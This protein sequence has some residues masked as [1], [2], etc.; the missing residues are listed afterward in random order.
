MNTAAPASL[1]S[2]SALPNRSHVRPDS[3]PPPLN[4]SLNTPCPAVP[5]H[6]LFGDSSTIELVVALMP[7]TRPSSTQWP[8]SSRRIDANPSSS[9][10]HSRRGSAFENRIAPAENDAPTF[11]FTSVAWSPSIWCS[12]DP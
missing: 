4:R 9:A 8:R 11:A 5:S 7:G 1:A 2:P 6:R 3:S 10:T 12:P